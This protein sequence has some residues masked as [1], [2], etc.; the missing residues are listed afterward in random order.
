MKLI[1]NYQLQS[2]D[3]KKIEGDE[4]HAGKILAN[5]LSMSNKG[6]AIKLYDW[7]LKLFNKEGIE[8]D[9]TDFQVLYA[10][11]ETTEFLTVLC[12]S[13]MLKGMNEDKERAAKK[14]K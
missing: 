1:F 11:I 7:A 13:Q 2:L 8:V 9:E 10:F 5:A 3:G 4:S 12:K 14:T 6:N